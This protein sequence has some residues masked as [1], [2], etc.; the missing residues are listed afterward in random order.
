MKKRVATAPAPVA[1][2]TAEL[3]AFVEIRTAPEASVPGECHVE[4][5]KM[6]G[7]KMRIHLRGAFEMELSTL[8][9]LFLEQRT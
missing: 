5:E 2:E 1:G 8:T 6:C 7:A 4:F 3:P 9:R